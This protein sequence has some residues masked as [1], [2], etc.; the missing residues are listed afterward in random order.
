MLE[1]ILAEVRLAYLIKRDKDGWNA[2]ANW[3]DALSGGEK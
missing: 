3:N 2:R 1:N